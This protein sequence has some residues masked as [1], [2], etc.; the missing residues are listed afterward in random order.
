MLVS[1]RCDVH[2]L[3]DLSMCELDLVIWDSH[4]LAL[5]ATPSQ[6]LIDGIPQ[7][8]SPHVIHK[9]SSFQ[10]SPKVPVFDKEASDAVKYEGLPPLRPRKSMTETTIFTNVKSLYTIGPEA[11][12]EVFSSQNETPF[13]VVVTHN[14]SVVCSGSQQTCMASAAF[15][16]PEVTIVDLEGGSISPGFVSFGSPLGLQHIDQEPSTNDGYVYDPLVK[17]V[18]KVLGGDTAIVRAIDGLLYGSR[19]AL[20][21]YFLT[22]FSSVAD[23]E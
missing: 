16:D 3:F 11:V 5:G 1:H 13:G 19:D 21:V 8:E 4:P 20:Y 17:A 10:K 18:P 7:L 15:D 6:V 22:E 23:I 9:P 12:R 14:G 2:L